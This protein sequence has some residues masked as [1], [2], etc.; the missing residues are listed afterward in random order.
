MLLHYIF[1]FLS[2]FYLIIEYDACFIIVKFT[3]HIPH[4]NT[5]T[6]STSLSY[7][8]TFPSTPY[9]SP[10]ASNRPLIL[11]LQIS[12]TDR[13]RVLLQ[14]CQ[15]PFA[16]PILLSM[17]KVLSR[18]STH[19]T[20][21]PGGITANGC[22]KRSTPGK[23]PSERKWCYRRFHSGYCNRTRA[24]TRN[25]GNACCYYGYKTFHWNYR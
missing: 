10:T 21:V 15:T 18:C 22:F 5:L 25:N 20:T 2:T 12:N 6:I 14:I 1:T 23:S 17:I 11:F 13:S 3:S 9:P 16:E 19:I 4:P 24:E 8:L 7:S